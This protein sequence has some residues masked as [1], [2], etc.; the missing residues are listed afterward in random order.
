MVD[1]CVWSNVVELSSHGL[2]LDADDQGANVLEPVRLGRSLRFKQ[3]LAA[4]VC[5]CSL[6]AVLQE[7]ARHKALAFGMTDDLHVLGFAQLLDI[8]LGDVPDIEFAAQPAVQVI[9]GLGRFQ[10]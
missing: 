4:C 1:D 9:E 5:W 3:Q 6:V 10:V 7:Q 8:E 2:A